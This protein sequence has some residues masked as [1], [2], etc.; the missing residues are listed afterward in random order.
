MIPTPTKLQFKRDEHLT[1]TWSDG[2]THVLPVE[3]LRRRCPCAACRDVRDTLDR[4]R[5]AIVKSTGSEKLA[6]IN[7]E[8]VGNYAIRIGW[9]D[10]HETGIYSFRHLYEIATR[11]AVE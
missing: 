6:A 2:V 10:G 5:L 4:S 7:V 8:A 9:S 3:L 11:Q 1:I